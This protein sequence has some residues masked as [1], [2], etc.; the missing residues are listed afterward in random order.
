MNPVINCERL[1]LKH[2]ICFVESFLL[3][4]H[5]CSSDKVQSEILVFP[6]KESIQP[7][8]MLGHV[9]FVDKEV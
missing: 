7:E 8:Y 4:D 3:L 9:A 5:S 6:C 2:M 1:K